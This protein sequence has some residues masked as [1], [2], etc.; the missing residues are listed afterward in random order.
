M[1]GTADADCTITHTDVQDFIDDGPAKL[2]RGD[3]TAVLNLLMG[4]LMK[5][6]L[7]GDYESKKG[8]GNA[9]LGL[10]ALLQ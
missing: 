8:T 2:A 10:P 6:G 5:E 7:G 3:M 9:V 4:S 1:T